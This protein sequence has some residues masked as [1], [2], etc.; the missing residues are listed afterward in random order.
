[1][2]KTLMFIAALAIA[3]AAGAIGS[4]A[5]ATNVDGWYAAIE[6]PFFNPPNWVFGPVWS[7]LYFWMGVSLYL[8]WIRPK[9][10]RKK[11]AFTLFGVQLMLNTLWSLVFFGLHAPWAGV[12]II[13]VL[14]A[15]IIG[16]IRLFWPLSRPA[17]LLLVPYAAWVSFATVLNVSIAVLN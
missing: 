15:C 17:A 4:I 2:K 1:M 16:T 6:K 3:F 12:G 5:T 9:D 7:I 14:L 10:E 8:L 11:A 13:V